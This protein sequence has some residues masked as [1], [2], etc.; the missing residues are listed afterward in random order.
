MF[1]SAKSLYSI[2]RRDCNG[3]IYRFH[4]LHFIKWEPIG[5]LSLFLQYGQIATQG[6]KVDLNHLIIAMLN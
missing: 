6:K 3:I 5:I 2:L 1:K 4:N